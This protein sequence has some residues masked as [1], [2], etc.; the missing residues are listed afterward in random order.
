M[1]SSRAIA[2]LDSCRRKR[3]KLPCRCAYTRQPN[4]GRLLGV[5]PNN[6]PGGPPP[7]FPSHEFF[8][9]RSA[10]VKTLLDRLGS[11]HFGHSAPILRAIA[12]GDHPPF[13][14]SDHSAR[15][16][17]DLCTVAISRHSP[18]ID[19]K[20]L[21]E[22]WRKPNS[23]CF[24]CPKIGSIIPFR[25]AYIS[26]PFFV[27][28]FLAILCVAESPAGIRPRGA[29]ATFSRDASADSVDRY[30]SMPRAA[31]VPSRSSRCSNRRR[32]TPPLIAS[33][34]PAASQVRLR[35]G[36]PSAPPA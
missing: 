32:S 17:G 25:F 20:P 35:P 18:R 8:G 12:E 22:N 3:F 13:P 29:A 11:P 1:R 5:R 34:T 2:L 21:S 9:G 6:A 36:P 31:P 24:N 14:L 27:L 26:R 16:S 15:A 19:A 23:T 30:A 10:A 4:S 28:S 33:L 7:G